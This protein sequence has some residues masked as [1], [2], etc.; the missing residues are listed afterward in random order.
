M[1][2]TRTV[3]VVDA[4]ERAASTVDGVERMVVRSAV[5][6]MAGVAAA[7]EAMVAE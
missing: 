4:V 1:H 3:V 2:N 5:V 7:E 6:G